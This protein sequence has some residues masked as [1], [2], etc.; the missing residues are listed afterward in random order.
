[1]HSPYIYD[2]AVE[3]RKFSGLPFVFACW[4]ANKPLD[5]G[6]LSRFNEAMSNISGNMNMIAEYYR[7]RAPDGVDL[8]EY[9]TNNISYPL[10]DDKRE[11]LKLFLQYAKEMVL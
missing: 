10:T 2:L 3:W 1:V 7:D 5:D 8:K 6:F 4:A 9:W 11:G